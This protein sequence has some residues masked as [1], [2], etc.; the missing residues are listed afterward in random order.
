MSNRSY[1][2]IWFFLEFWLVEKFLYKKIALS[3]IWTIK[4]NWKQRWQDQCWLL[5]RSQ[6]A[7]GPIIEFVFSRILIGRKIFII[8]KFFLLD[9]VNTTKVNRIFSASLFTR[10]SI[11]MV[12]KWNNWIF[13]SR[14]LIGR[15]IFCKRNCFPRISWIQQRSILFFQHHCSLVRR[16]QWWK[17]GRIE[18]E[19]F[20][21]S[22]WSKNFDGKKIF[23]HRF[24]EYNK[25]QWNFFSIS[26]HSSH[27]SNEQKVAK[28]IFIFSRNLIGGKILMKKNFFFPD[29]E[30]TGNVNRIFSTSVCD[31]SEFREFRTVNSTNFEKTWV[32]D[33]LIFLQI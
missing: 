24:C 23:S 13:F 28:F 3:R 29:F 19:F 20:S 7:T 2:S 9:F 16:F 26:V 22:D 12:K 11:P 17:S 15:K 6:W 25:G 32:Y 33:V 4:Q 30:N 5:R 18:F 27:D 1:N 21:N 10:A 8:K 31:L 14:I